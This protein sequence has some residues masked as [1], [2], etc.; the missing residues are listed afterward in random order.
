MI[1]VDF[2]YI[3]IY[4][5]GSLLL[6][7][8]ITTIGTAFMFFIIKSWFKNRTYTPLSLIVGAVVFL[9]LTYHSIIICGAVTIKG[10]GDDVESLINSY[11][12]ILPD[13][14]VLTEEDSNIILEKLNDDIPLVGHYADYADFHGHTPADIATSMNDAMQSYMNGYIIRHLLWSLFFILLGAFVVIK[15]MDSGTTSRKMFSHHARTK[16]YDE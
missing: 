3:I 7:L 8:L 2:F 4:S 9:F 11:V 12:S 6:G 5:L 14:A 16:F 15:T 10:Y 13:D 1:D